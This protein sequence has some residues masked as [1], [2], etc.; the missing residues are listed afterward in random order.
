LHL[1]LR[2]VFINIL[3]NRFMRD[4]G[5][6]GGI[7]HVLEL[8]SRTPLRGAT[9]LHVSAAVV[10]HPIPHPQP[11]IRLHLRLDHA[12]AESR[13]HCRRHRWQFVSG[14][15]ITV[16][17]TTTTTTTTTGGSRHHRRHRRRSNLPLATYPNYFAT[18]M[19]TA[20]FSRTLV[21]YVLL[22]GVVVVWSYL[23]RCNHFRH[24]RT[25]AR[26]ARGR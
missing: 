19:L 5:L 9:R 25:T 11:P 20:A 17:V 16:T 24:Q 14:S 2:Y 15:C 8:L 4:T 23:R 12:E 22:L 1:S 18:K 21:F 3:T 26:L 13:R 7:C 6:P 10:P